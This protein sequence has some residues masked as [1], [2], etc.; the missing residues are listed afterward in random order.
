MAIV[1]DY[2]LNPS[3]RKKH[4]TVEQYKSYGRSTGSKEPTSSTTSQPCV[5]L[6]VENCKDCTKDKAQLLDIKS[7]DAFVMMHLLEDLLK[8]YDNVY[9]CAG[10]R[11][12]KVTTSHFS[13]MC[14]PS[15]HA[16]LMR[17]IIKR[18]E[19]RS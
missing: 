7:E 8:I 14:N 13:N 6:C 4:T 15:G 1:K 12:Q 19:G 10:G 5:R 3:L 17:D 11:D 16:R 9:F 2:A 18:I